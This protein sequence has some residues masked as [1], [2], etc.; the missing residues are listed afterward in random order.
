MMLNNDK[1]T[2]RTPEDAHAHMAQAWQWLCEQRTAAPDNADV[3]HIRWAHLNTGEGWLTA[4]TD[5]L[6][7]G[8]YR[9]TPLQLQGQNESRKAVWGAQDALV[10]KWV[11]LCLQHQLPPHP[12]CEHVTGHGGGKQSIETLHHLL[13]DNTDVHEKKTDDSNARG[14]TWVCRTD[15]RGYYRNINK[16]TLINQVNQHVTS[17]ALR[18]LVHQYIHYTVEDGGTFHTPEQGISRGCPLSPLMGAL[19]LYDMDEHFSQQ[20]NIYY[21]RYMDDVIILAKTRWQLRKHTKRLMQWFGEY[22]FEAH[23]DKTYIGRTEKGFDWMGAWLTSDGVTDIAP[24]AKANHREKVRRLYEQLARLPTWKRKSAAPQVHARVS[25]YR[26]RWTI[27]AGALMGLASNTAI[28]ADGPLIV[29]GTGSGPT[30]T[31]QLGAA[32]TSTGSKSGSMSASS[33]GESDYGGVCLAGT[34]QACQGVKKWVATSTPIGW[35]LESPLVRPG[36]VLVASG[37][38]TVSC[39]GCSGDTVASLDLATGAA[40]TKDGRHYT[41]CSPLPGNDSTRST[42]Y[43]SSIKSSCPYDRH[44]NAWGSNYVSL[45]YNVYLRPYAMSPQPAGAF[46]LPDLFVGIH[47]WSDVAIAVD[48]PNAIIFSGLQCSFAGKTNY[49]LGNADTL[50]SIGTPVAAVNL[51][52]SGLAVTCTGTNTAGV[53]VPISYTLQP[54][55]SN[56]ATNRTQLT[57]NLQP[58]FYMLFTNDGSASCNINDPKAI[59][60]NGVTPTTITDVKPGDPMASAPVPLGATLCSTGDATQK[61]GTYDMAVTASIVSY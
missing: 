52:A 19:H 42:W 4:L 16:Q 27:W 29:M 56:T 21:A 51:A 22:G 15:I 54:T 44:L 31:G 7:R 10:L 23:P 6:L 48:K 30:P 43:T 57:N 39:A 11:A 40:T 9:L 58:S 32:F 60:L 17:P 2:D 59:P 50:G 12:S 38:A 25:T 20:P 49:A 13:T 3:W 55:G 36:L 35:G 33:N 8:D 45:S 47:S 28:S 5:R 53:S 46:V 18:G 37:S 1:Q 14:Y 24:R 61:P 26:K 34:N 41:A